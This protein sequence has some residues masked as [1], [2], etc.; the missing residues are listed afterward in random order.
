MYL[1]PASAMSGILDKGSWI[2]A[3]IALLLVSFA[4]YTTVNS[5]LQRT[6]AIPQFYEFYNPVFS[7]AEEYTPEMQAEYRKAEADFQKA[8]KE[9]P[10]IPLV[11]DYFFT[12]F[13]FDSNFFTPLIAISLFYVPAAI[14]LMVIFGGLGNFGVI[15]KRDYATLATCSMMAWTAAHLPFAI[16]GI[17]L[18]TTQISPIAFLSFWFAGSLLFGFFMI[19]ALRTIFGANY[20]IAVSIVAVNWLAISLGMYIFAFVSPWIFSPFLLFFAVL[21]F[22]GF[23]GGEVRGL[24]SAFRGRQNFKRHLQNATVNPNDADARVQ[25][26]LI[27]LKRRQEEKAFEYFTEA[28]EIDKEEIDANFEL[29]KFA[30]KRG[31][32]QKALNYFSTVVAQNDKH[33]LSEIRREIGATYLEAGM[34]TEA[35]DWL[36]KFIERRAFDA[37]GLYYLGKVLKEQGETEAANEKFNEAIESV[38]TA[39]YHRR[40]ELK[41][42][43]K[44]AQKEI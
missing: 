28:F 36:E 5:N 23:L 31:E 43:S 40:G 9:R 16:A 1:R 20:T 10:K 34:L 15:F 30:R 2:F 35:R 19:F 22:G 29:G 11:G 32:L 25:L 39:V 44:L 3:A 18:F 7:G 27:Y 41:K 17:F 26:G 13:S 8:S 21:Y 33:A 37:E 38:K 4:F 6:Y 12:F 24:G 42:W 14:L